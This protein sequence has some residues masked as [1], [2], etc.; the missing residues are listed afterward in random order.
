MAVAVYRE[1]PQPAGS[2]RNAFEVT[3]TEIE[4]LG[5]RIRIH[6]DGL[7]ADVTVQAAAELDLVAGR[8]VT[9]VVKATEVA[10]Y[11]R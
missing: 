11:S 7:H 10:I 3:V 6:A 2:P 1:R 4:P 5:D 8:V 9:F